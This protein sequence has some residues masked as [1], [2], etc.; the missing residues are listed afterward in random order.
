MKLWP[1]C[2]RAT[3]A[4]SA[5]LTSR[6]FREPIQTII[7]VGEQLFTRKRL[8]ASVRAEFGADFWGF[9]MLGGMSGG[10]MGFHFRARPQ[11]GGAKRLQE[12]M[13]Q[14]KR[15]LQ[16]ALPFAMEPVVYD[17]AI[18]ERGTWADLLTRRRRA[19]AARL[20][21]AGRPAL[22]RADP[23]T[24]PRCAARNWTNSAPPAARGRIL[25]H[26]AGRFRPPAA[27]IA[28]GRPAASKAWRNCWS[29]TVLTAP[30]RADSRRFEER[31]H[32]P[33]AKPPAGQR[34]HQGRP[35]RMF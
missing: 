19:A 9:W 32:R 15:E 17:F 12:I 28:A 16:H 5:R 10:G 33:G 26:D 31:P 29:K 2:A 7:P 11:S 30:A 18:N 35:T 21:R 4:A 3:C 34:R 6:N 27:A 13:S 22:A 8:I 1:R 14:T 23:Q 25:R 24:L 20:L